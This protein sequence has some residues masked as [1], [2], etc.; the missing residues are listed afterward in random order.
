[1]ILFFDTETTG[2]PDEAL[3]IT[4][5]RQPHLVQLAALLTDT[6]GTERG[7]MSVV[8]RPTDG[9]EIPNNA[10]AI[11]GITT[12]LAKKYGVP[13]EAVM[14][15]FDGLMSRTLKVAA[16]NIAFDKRIMEISA[17]R[18]GMDQVPWPHQPDLICTMD[19]CRSIVQ[20]PPTS[21]MLAAGFK[22][23]KSPKLE[24]AYRHFFGEDL[25]NAHDAMADVRACAR[26]FFHLQNMEAA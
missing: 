23:W 18:A 16:H 19:R 11:H 25:V 24:E 21:R 8:I 26:L 12:E 22:G 1:M 9:Y 14:R 20:M 13:L 6:G 2:F 5:S 17:R 4:D 7:S 10:A 3:S 15:I